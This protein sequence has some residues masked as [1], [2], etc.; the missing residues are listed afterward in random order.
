MRP[1]WTLGPNPPLHTLATKIIGW[2]PVYLENRVN[3][4]RV[5]FTDR[6][7]EYI[8]QTAQKIYHD[9][10]RYHGMAQKWMRRQFEDAVGKR[11]YLPLLLPGLWELFSAMKCRER[12]DSRNDGVTGY[13]NPKYIE[14]IKPRRDK[15]ADIILKG[16]SKMHVFMSCSLVQER[17]RESR[18]FQDL[19]AFRHG[20]SD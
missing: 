3:G 7:E 19:Y 9:L 20:C 5:L 8:T 18:R 4:S 15:T 14:H 11:Q 17:I 2:E 10:A 1:D 12:P 16:D 6:P 13:V